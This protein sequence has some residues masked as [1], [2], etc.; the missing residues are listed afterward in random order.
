MIVI[1]APTGN[2]GREL[3]SLLLDTAPGERLRVVATR[4]ASP[5]RCAT[6]SR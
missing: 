1:T 5:T 4:P 3:L 6:G 2:I